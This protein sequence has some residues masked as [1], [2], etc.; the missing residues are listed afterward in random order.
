MWIPPATIVI[1]V[2]LYVLWR[3]DHSRMSEPRKAL[4]TILTV[5]TWPLALLLL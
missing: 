4:L 2:S 1:L 5:W 3:I